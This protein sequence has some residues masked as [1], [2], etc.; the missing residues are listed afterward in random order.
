[1]KFT[2]FEELN[3]WKESIEIAKKIY[4]ITGDSLF[5]KD[6]ALRDQLRRAAIS[7]S[8]NIVEGFERDNNNEFVRYLKIAK[9]STG[10]VRSQLYLSKEIGYVSS[11]LFL[12]MNTKL[13]DLSL[14]IG[15]L[16]SYLELKRSEGEFFPK[17]VNSRT[18]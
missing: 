16:I 18:R 3:I 10:E 7:I 15:K 12:G 2:S 14:Q 4:E 5:A 11:E 17:P 9:G 1:M 6:F 8:S 13:H